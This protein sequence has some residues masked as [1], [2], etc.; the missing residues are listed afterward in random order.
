VSKTLHGAIPNR[1]QLSSRHC[2]STGPYRAF[3]ILEKFEEITIRE[4]RVLR[5][6]A[7]VPTC[8]TF[9]CANP[10]SA[11]TSDEQAEDPVGRKLL[12]CRR[13]PENTSDTIESKQSEFRTEPEITIGCLS[14]R[15]DV[16]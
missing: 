3:M 8:K 6:L 15:R 9:C 10:K 13:T 12:I 16:A 11:I 5:K 4:F 7:V 2:H 1:T 14:D